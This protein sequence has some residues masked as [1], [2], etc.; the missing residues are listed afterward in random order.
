MLHPILDVTTIEY[1]QDSRKN[2]CSSIQHPIIMTEADYDYILD[3][4]GVMKYFS[5]KEM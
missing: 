3:E 2:I 1:A 5:L 4:I